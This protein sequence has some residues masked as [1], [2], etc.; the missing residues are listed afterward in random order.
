MKRPIDFSLGYAYSAPCQ[1]RIKFR[2]QMAFFFWV[3]PGI[4]PAPRFN[5]NR[6]KRRICGPPKEG[7]RKFSMDPEGSPFLRS[8]PCHEGS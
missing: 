1:E 4:S 8:S 6:P 3:V 7:T 2:N 5:S